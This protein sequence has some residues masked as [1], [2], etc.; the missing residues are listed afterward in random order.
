[1]STNIAETSVTID[2]VV[3]VIDSGKIK[4]K[5]FDPSRN[6]NML[7]VQV[8]VSTFLFFIEAF[9]VPYNTNNL[10]AVDF[11]SKCTTEARKGWAREGWFLLP[12]VHKRG[13]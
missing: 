2:D 4:E 7:R 12:I 10:Y 8:L 5:Q 11:S 13:V 9:M 3:Y 1:M 6:M